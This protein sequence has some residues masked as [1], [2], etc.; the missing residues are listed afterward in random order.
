MSR[1]Q[2]EAF[3]AESFVQPNDK[4]I[5]AMPIDLR[6][7]Q[8][9]IDML[10]ES[11]IAE[12]EIREGEDSVRINRAHSNHTV[13][14][15]IQQTAPA[16]TAATPS[17]VTVPQIQEQP[18]VAT[19]IVNSKQHTVR[20]PMVGTFYVAPAPNAKPFVEIGQAVR[21]GDV[22]CIVEAMKML[23]Q[24]ESDKDGII[25]SRLVDNGMPV[26]FDQPL[27]IIE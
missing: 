24:I 15:S 9:I 10:A 17:L 20:S 6:K 13:V 12:I 8:K 23:N 4:R 21:A 2:K 25:V 18:L 11:D 7:I 27:F 3:N 26:E 5:M 16:P 14:P 1:R 22:L 19:P